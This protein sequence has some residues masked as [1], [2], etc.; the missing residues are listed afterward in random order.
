MQ[1][2]CWPSSVR[3]H[4][5]QP[6]LC[7]VPELWS[8][9]SLCCSMVLHV[10]SAKPLLLSN[11]WKTIVPEW[12]SAHIQIN[13]PHECACAPS[14]LPLPSSTPIKCCNSQHLWRRLGRGMMLLL[15]EQPIWSAI[16]KLDLEVCKVWC[17]FPDNNPSDPQ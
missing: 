9:P 5:K 4:L 11:A 17:S 15:R 14:P 12:R 16:G 13:N 6:G 10:Q 3:T 7:L 2:Q 8:T 1:L